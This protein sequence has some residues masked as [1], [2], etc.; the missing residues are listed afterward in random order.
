VRVPFLTIAVTS[1]LAGCAA[2]V[3][4]SALD[5]SLAPIQTNLAQTNLA[6]TNLQ[7]CRDFTTQ[8]AVEGQMRQGVGQTCLQPDGSWRV[9]LNTPG[10]PE[11]T[12][13]LPPQ[14]TYPYPYAYADPSYW[15]D[16]WFYGP[17]FVSNRVFL[18][19]TFRHHHFKQGGYHHGGHHG[20]HK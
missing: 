15:A 11:Q 1:F 8:V 3:P 17:V 6:Q 2:Q 10:L 9:T 16:P 18:V 7:N 20:G 14:G 5:T 4:P 12:Y 13:T 19:R